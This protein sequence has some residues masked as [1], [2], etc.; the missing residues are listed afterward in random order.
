MTPSESALNLFKGRHFDREV[1]VLCVRWYLSYKLNSRDLVEMMSE[2]G[3]TLAHTTI[4]RWV[5]RYVPVFEKQWS[6]YTR[7]VGGSWRCD[8]TYIKVNDRWTYLYRA[9]DKQGRTVDF[10]LSERRDV[11][12]AKRFFRK[13]MKRHPTPRVITLDAYAASHRAIT[14]LKSAGTMP[15]RVR[16]RSSKYLNNVVEADHGAIKRRIRSML[17]FKSA[18][19]AYAT[20]K[21][22]EVMRMIRKLQC[23]LL[24]PGVIAEARFFNKLFG[25][26]A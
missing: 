6:H 13:A 15:H 1:I 4:L 5:Q 7:P 3:I 9:V 12:A 24:R 14:E 11:A 23:I 8:E 26:Y 2:R 18:K 10:L 19:T 22:I 17:G 20:L 25:V 16:I 21:G